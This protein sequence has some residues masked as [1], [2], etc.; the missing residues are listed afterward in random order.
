MNHRTLKLEIFYDHPL[1][2]GHAPWGRC[3]QDDMELHH[4]LRGTLTDLTPTPSPL[5]FKGTM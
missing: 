3:W 4:L 5:F 2:T 1:L